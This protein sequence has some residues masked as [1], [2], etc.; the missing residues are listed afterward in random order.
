M[1]GGSERRQSPET[2]Q[3]DLYHPMAPL[4][5]SNKVP[6]LSH[7]LT[8]SL[9]LGSLPFTNHF[10]SWTRPFHVPSPSDW[11]RLFLIQTFSHINTPTIS[12]QL[13]FL[14]TPPM[15]VGQNVPKCQHIKFRPPGVSPK[16]KNT[17]L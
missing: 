5:Q 10:S 17:S 2:Q 8:T 7:I 3:S 6:F 4:P 13:T 11:L 9:H 15:K 16:T 1:P 12:S 14:L